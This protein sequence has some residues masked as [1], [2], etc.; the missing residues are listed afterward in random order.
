MGLSEARTLIIGWAK[1]E[2]GLTFVLTR[3]SGAPR[4]Q[5]PYGTLQ[6]VGNGSRVNGIDELRYDREE[7]KFMQE[8]VRSTL[9]SLNILGKDANDLMS[10]LRDSLDRPDVI[11][12]FARGNIA[13]ISEGTPQDLSELE[14]TK[15]PERSQLDLTVHFTVSYETNVQPIEEV[16]ITMEETPMGTQTINVSID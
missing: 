13:V 6:F 1:R 11:E 16:E 5:L 3:Q 15:T 12:E 2:T 7:E 14:D 4:P 10:K 8:G 9:V